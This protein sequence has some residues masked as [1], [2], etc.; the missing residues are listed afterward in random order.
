MGP[1][2]A[3]NWWACQQIPQRGC[4]SVREIVKE[5]KKGWG[6]KR[7]KTGSQ[8]DRQ[9]AEC[10]NWFNKGRRSAPGEETRRLGQSISCEGGGLD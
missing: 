2:A 10:I 7:S 1:A 6:L 9:C 3:S 4:S 5:G 8:S